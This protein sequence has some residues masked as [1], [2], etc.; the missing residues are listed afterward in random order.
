MRIAPAPFRRNTSQ[1]ILAS[2]I[3]RLEP[4]HLF[5]VGGGFV[6]AGLTGQYFNNLTLSG[7]PAF[8]R[9]DV[10]V[11]ANWNGASPAG[12]SS[13]GFATV[14]GTNWSAKWT[15]SIIPTYSEAYTF[16]TISDDGV[17]LVV[18]GKTLI[19]D[20][21]D[22][23]ASTDTGTI[24]LVAGHAYSIELDYYQA[25]G[26]SE[27]HLLWS[28][29]STP[30]EVI[31]P[32]TPVGI[33][34]GTAADYD[35]SLMFAD[36]VKMSRGWTSLDNI[37]GNPITP[38]ATDWPTTDA[39]LPLFDAI[40]RKGSYG[41]TF[42]GAATLAIGGTYPGVTISNQQYDPTT[43]ITTATITIPTDGVSGIGQS[44]L[45]LLF[46]NTQ[47][48]A[49]SGINTGVTNVTLMRPA[50]DGSATPLP[51][52]TLFTPDYENLISNFS[53]IRFMDYLHTN[54]STVTTWAD[55][56]LPGDITQN[57]TSGGSLEYAVELANET[58]KDLW[59][60]IPFGANDD[61]VTNVANLLKYGSDGVNP[62]TTV[63]ANPLYAPLNSGLKV[64]V[65]YSNEN[66]GFNP[67]EA[68]VAAIAAAGVGDPI[69]YDGLYP[70]G[71][72]GWIIAQ[73]WVAERAM[74][75]SN[76]FRTVYGNSDMPGSGADATVRP[77]FEWQYGGNW[78]QIGLDFL[79]DYYNN[80][81]GV[82][83]V[84]APHPV[85]YFFWGG[86]G[87]WYSNTHNDNAGS[88]D[89]IY[90]SGLSVSNSVLADVQLAAQFGLEDVGYEGGFKVGNDPPT[91]LQIQATIDPRAQQMTTDTLNAFFAAGG[92]L[93]VVYTAS[94]AAHYNYS[95]EQDAS[96]ATDIF[97]QNT[98]RMQAYT[99]A[100]QTLPP[101]S[102]NGY[103][104]PGNAGASLVI[105]EGDVFSGTGNAAVASYLLNAPA[106]GTYTVTIQG[107]TD[108]TVTTQ[109]LMLDG[110]TLG[111]VAVPLWSAVPDVGTTSCAYLHRECR[112]RVWPLGL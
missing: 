66:W 59:I 23:A 87:A 100:E 41:L 111:S 48:T 58:G 18:D 81:D 102:T 90:N 53:T 94:G 63:Q 91:D 77:L 57:Q 1:Q 108:S 56:T 60:N 21:T 9:T 30:Q 20:W 83:H 112:G 64:Y 4:R 67:T 74:Q 54:N 14:A 106:A 95:V 65:E 3:E 78:G 88:I 107:T 11:D 2:I 93:P 68:Q 36:A 89:D 76:D 105:S 43:N 101:V 98:P 46:T 37:W 7:S 22:H 97:N 79:N 19:N 52:G 42:N 49:D 75:I 35:N 27:L 17:R 29:A 40:D 34:A 73:R 92:A 85:N 50:T 71:D 96:G 13:P 61:Y 69:N 25:G 84:A 45:A 12:S 99:E 55:R 104:L 39:A 16:T 72:G 33:N 103:T 26:G 109:H 15:G 44:S 51:A 31:E 5:S 110:T 47:Q 32:A 10:R 86:G 82:Q 24:N 28:S 6:G 80:A 70:A 62:Y 38:S 8:T